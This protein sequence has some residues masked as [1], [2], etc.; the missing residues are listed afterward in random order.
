MLIEPKLL[1][2]EISLPTVRLLKL[3]FIEVLRL[4]EILNYF[5]N[6]IESTNIE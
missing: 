3:I 5:Y 4:L 2:T 6:E 1:F